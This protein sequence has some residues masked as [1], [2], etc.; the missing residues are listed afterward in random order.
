MRLSRP[1]GGSLA[2][3][4]TACAIAR[5][6]PTVGRTVTGNVAGPGAE[7]APHA[8]TIY[9]CATRRLYLLLSAAPRAARAAERGAGSEHLGGH[10]P[11]APLRDAARRPATAAP[12]AVPPPPDRAA[13]PHWRPLAQPGT[14]RR[15][16]AAPRRRRVGAHHSRRRG[17]WR[18][19][20][21][22]RARPCRGRP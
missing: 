9:R 15:F 4:G 19:R 2:I 14:P 6:K 13:P 8:K 3:G 7:R 20:G 1:L 10:Y 17:A 5:P 12:R 11:A 21:G 22:S 16:A 18:A